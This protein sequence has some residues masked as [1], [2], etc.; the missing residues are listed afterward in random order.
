MPST[1]STPVFPGILEQDL[2]QSLT[3]IYGREYGIQYG[4]VCFE[5]L[6][7]ALPVEAAVR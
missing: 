7:T 2:A 4:Q 1:T 3:E 6:P 5:I